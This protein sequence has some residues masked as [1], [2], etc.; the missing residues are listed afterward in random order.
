M[1]NKSAYRVESLFNT[2]HMACAVYSSKR[3]PMRTPG[4]SS[5]LS[6]N[7]PSL[8]WFLTK[9]CFPAPL[10]VKRP[11][12]VTDPVANPVICAYVYQCS[13]V[14][15]EKGGDVVVGCV[16]PIFSQGES[17]SNI[18]TAGAEVARDGGIHAQLFAHSGAIKE[19]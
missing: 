1:I 6:L 2:D 19:A 5:N 11:G 4:L 17:L 14:A 9:C 15:L 16:I 10:H 18:I 13:Y 7:Q 3:E 12:L 8:K